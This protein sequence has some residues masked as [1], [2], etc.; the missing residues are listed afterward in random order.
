MAVPKVSD[1]ELTGLALADTLSILQEQLQLTVGVRQQGVKSNNFSTVN[2]AVTAS[3]DQTALTPMV[4]LVVKPWNNV[5]FYANYIEGL[6]KGDVAPTTAGNAGE[7]LS[8][9]VSK[10]EEVGVKVD[11]GSLA[12]T[13]SGFEITKP[14]RN[15]AHGI[16]G[17]RRT[18]LAAWNSM[19]LASCILGMPVLGGVTLIDAELTKTGIP[20]ALGKRPIGVSQVQANLS[21]ELDISFV[22]GLTL[23][24]STVYTGAQYVDA[25]N[26]RSIPAWTRLDLGARYNTNINGR[27]VT[28][29]A[30]VQNVFDTNYWS[31]VSS[32]PA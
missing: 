21:T 22:P 20:A 24:A 32:F 1:T 7:V 29:R 30:L 27:P 15:Y 28:V 10:Q 2:G 5:A 26:T 4:G 11:L 8:P 31:G 14:R 18:A 6:S 3:Y 13:I 12:V 17:R 25:I 23:I 9:Y 16:P 19:C